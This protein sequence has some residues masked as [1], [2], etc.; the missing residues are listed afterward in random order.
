VVSAISVNK[1]DIKVNTSIDEKDNI[2]KNNSVNN[3]GLIFKIGGDKVYVSYGFKGNI[4]VGET[5]N[6]TLNTSGWNYVT[7]RFYS[8]NGIDVDIVE[9]NVK[10]IVGVVENKLENI[11]K[12]DYKIKGGLGNVKISIKGKNNG[13]YGIVVMGVKKKEGDEKPKYLEIK[14]EK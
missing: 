8:D 2:L 7:I 10:S 9:G 4:F 11:K 6:Y 1:N 14:L 3:K 5:I 12:K 13:K